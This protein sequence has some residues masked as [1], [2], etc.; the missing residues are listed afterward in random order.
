[1]IWSS[2]YLV[3]NNS[4][5][6]VNSGSL[7]PSSGFLTRQISFLLNNYVYRVGEDK[8]N[9]GLLIPRYKALGR[10]APNGK[11]YPDKPLVNGS[12]DDLVPVRSIVVKNKGNLSEVTPDLIGKKFNDF[13]DGAALGLSFATSLTEGI[14]QSALGL[15]HG[16]ENPMIA[17]YKYN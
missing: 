17:V 10:T 13:T 12:E 5:L 9:P 15:K 8:E 7:R 4:I 3:C 6:L 16:D 11:V 14:T 1:M 2:Y